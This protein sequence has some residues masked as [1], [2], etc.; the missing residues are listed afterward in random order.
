[1]TSNKLVVLKLDGDFHEGFRAS[2]TISVEGSLPDIELSDNTLKLPPLPTLPEIYQTWSK[3]YRSLDGYRIKPKKDQITNVRFQSLKTE[4]H[5]QADILKQQ[6]INWLQADSFQR[7]KEVCLSQLN[8][9]DEVRVIIRTNETQLRKLPWQLWNLFTYYPHAEVAFSSLTSQRIKTSNRPHI[10]ILIILGNSAGINVA[11]DEKLLKQYCQAAEIVVLAEPTPAELN[12]Y[13]WYETGWDILFFSGHSRTESTQGRIFLNRT[14][15]LTM[16][17]L[18]YGLQTAVSKGLQLAF[19]NS[20]DGLGIAAELETLHIPQVIVMREPVPDQ[21]A[22]QFLKDFIQ[23]FTNNKSFYQSVNIARKKLQGLE[24]EYPCASWLPIIVQNLLATP[25]TWQSLGAVTQCPYRGLAAFQAQDAAYFYGR[26]TVTQ[27]LVAAVKK[28]HLV[29][30]VGASGSGKSS[31]VFAG[32]IP[33]LKRERSHHWQIV[34][35]RPGNNPLESLAIALHQELKPGERLQ[36]LEFEIRL[37]ESQNTFQ[38]FLESLH[39]AAPN[40]HI[41]LIADQ[42]EELYTLCQNSKERQIFLDHLLTAVKTVPYFTLVLTL[43]ADFFGEVLSYRPLSDALQDAQINLGAMNPKELA[44]AI[45]K[46]AHS[47]NVQLE[48][49]LTQRLID[50]VLTSPSHL[51]LL[52]FTLTQLWEK[53]QKGWLT[54]QAYTDIGGVETALANHAESIYTQLSAAEQ[55]K[56]RQIF[57]QL[58]QPTENN[59]DIRRLATR[60][61]LGEENWK[62]VAQL[63]NGRLLVTNRHEI[64]NIETVEIIHEALIKNWLRLKQWMET[65]GEFR[66]WQEQLRVVI[67]QWE[68]SNKDTGA[69]LRGKPLIDAA[70]WLHQRPT[71]ISA[72]EQ[73]FINFSLELQEREEQQ[74]HTVKQRIIISLSTGLIGALIL[75]VFALS[76]WQQS[77][78]LRQEIQITQLNT[79]SY[80][81]SNNDQIKT[82]ISTID[83]LKRL[84]SFK[85]LDT[86]TKIGL[87]IPVVENLRQIKEYNRLESHTGEV[88][89]LNFSANGQLL[90][91]ASG[92]ETIKIWQKNG[93]LIQ[94]LTGHQQS[95]FTVMFSQ[96][97][98]LVIAGSFDNTVTIWRYNSATGLFDTRPVVRISEPDGLLATRLTPDSK[99]LATGNKKGQVKFWTLD[100]KL[101]KTIAAH[102]Q[103]IWSLSF[104]PNGKTFATASAD[105]TVKIWNLEGKLVKTLSGHSEEVLSV[106]FSPD[107]Q[108]LATAS[109]DKTVK[110]WDVRGKLLHTFNG[111]EDEVLDV[112]FSPDSKL[113]ASASADNTVKIW[114]IDTKTQLYTLSGHGSKASEVSFSPDSQT[115]ATASA[116]NSI[117]LWRLEG[118]S[119]NFIGNHISV[120]PDERTIVISDKQGIITLRKCD[121][122]LLHSFPAHQGEIIK[123]LFN[124]VDNNFVTIGKDHQIKIWNLSGNLLKNWQVNHRFSNHIDVIDEIRDASVSPDGKILATVG[125]RENKIK[126]WNLDGNLLKTWQD[127]TNL[128]TTIQFSPDGQT[129]ATNN[130]QTVNLWNLQGDLLKIISG[131]QDNITSVV[132]SYDGKIIATASLDKTVKIW[133]SHSGKLLRTFEHQD[134][135]YDISFS[136]D[137][138]VLISASATQVNF[139]NLAGEL[140]HTLPGLTHNIKEVNFS[141]NGNIIT[142]VDV[143]NNIRLWDLNT[144]DLQQRSCDWLKDYFNTNPNL[145]IEERRLCSQDK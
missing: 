51:P 95:V 26:E 42:F 77:E 3:S 73:I 86:K 49:G 94:T 122:S 113:I 60:E 50:V 48:P 67:R 91:S 9:D 31:V 32:L 126:L 114:S 135:V 14:D 89:S 80:L 53:Q 21:V 6:F 74:K 78:R 140:L 12:Q 57:I 52:E 93:Q 90:A 132:Y 5:T 96:D 142:L 18:R 41:V 75:S 99:M 133:D 47:L 46:P 4:C 64:T 59:A 100:G 7:I 56:V 97:S 131:H 69:L 2:L 55:E 81:N 111:H 123:V 92:D 137:S 54:H 107:S 134:K 22:H 71:E 37:K 128:V 84:G 117:K 139:W 33:Q 129:L 120:S 101:I 58:V 68:N 11:E 85:Q 103:K 121:G 112:G 116:D 19:F 35:F 66:R 138:Q 110:L 13:L 118:M 141:A 15:S 10:R 143:Q 76:Q 61:E 29:A 83:V 98:Q 43:R 23:Q 30:V 115:I 125:G 62:L 63:A 70:E 144:Q 20:C 124:P 105:K 39:T 87:L 45:E 136:P 36:E 127:K 44:A 106:N 145:G 28:Q 109:K 82:L 130:D 17:Q 16:E 34:S 8:S 72:N 119:P 1:M 102:N 38:N 25:P 40:S 79:L 24:T 108:K 65:D 88:T 104:S 27:Q